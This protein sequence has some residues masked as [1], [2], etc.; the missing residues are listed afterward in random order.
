MTESGL[1]GRRSTRLIQELIDAVHA[2]LGRPWRSVMVLMAYVLGIAALV[3]SIGITQAT[4]ASVVQRLT[5]A[6]SSEV[7][8]GDDGAPPQPWTSSDPGAAAD[9]RS[10]VEA[11]RTLAALEGV[12]SA[13]PVRSFTAVGNTITRLDTSGGR[14]R[15]RIVITTPAYFA[16]EDLRATSGHTTTFDQPYVGAAVALGADAARSLDVAAAEEG[17]AIWVNGRVIPVLAVLAPS[18]RSETDNTAYFTPAALQVLADQL[19]SSWIVHTEQGYAEPLALAIPLALAADNPGRISVSAVAAL[20]SLQEGINTDLGSL[21]LVIG[22]VILVLSAL[23]AGA[24]MF[25][26]VQHRQ[27]EIA[28]RRSMGGSRASIWRLFTYEGAAIGLSGGILGTGLGILL[29]ALLGRLNDW[30]LAIGTSIVAG[31]VLTGL[32]AGVIASVVPAISAAR[33]D[34]A[35][36]L[37][38]A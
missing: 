3:G 19:E 17:V 20:R 21:L 9:W 14:F 12:L 4:T 28:L 27:A 18:G 13:V 23:T 2:P 29:A 22:G 36:I 25:L 6:A 34:P 11:A 31:G 5:D 32:L 37:R 8:V 16:A 35:G 1:T 15:G 24:T 30:P 7:R 33:Q 26:S 38:A 10:Q